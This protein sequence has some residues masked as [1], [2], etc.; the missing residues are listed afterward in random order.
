MTMA[1]A[2]IP[3]LIGLDWG[4]T[5]LRAFVIAADGS[6]LDETASGHGLRHLPAPGV[7]GFE[8]ALQAVAGIWRRQWPTLPLLACGMVGSAQGWREAPYLDCPT[9]PAALARHAAR[10]ALADGSTLHIA[11]GLRHRPADGGAPDVMRGEEVQIAGA[12]AARGLADAVVV[13]PGTHAKWARVR[14]GRVTAFRTHMTGELYA[15]L[16]QHSLLGQLMPAEGGAG[17][18]TAAAIAFERGLAM[19]R[20]AAPGELTHQL[21]AVRTLALD[22]QVPPPALADLLSGL[23][24]GHELT[25]ALAW[26]EREGHA[27]APLLLVGEGALSRRYAAALERAGRPATA[28]LGNTAPQGLA[29]L[30]REGGLIHTPHAP[31]TTTETLR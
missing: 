30:A 16:R 28:L 4:T 27:G 13:L 25:A 29:R 24:I 22:G 19:A 14:G 17:D 6:V 5:R 12:L 21:F 8:A 1:P 15:V 2:L 9:D 11:P 31:N 3:A 10:V 26:L 18:A 20:D 7:A 23:L